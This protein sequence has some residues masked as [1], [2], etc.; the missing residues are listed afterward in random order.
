[1]AAGTGLTQDASGL[2]LTAIT[3]GNATVGAVRYNSTTSTAGQFYGGTT[4]PSG[5]TRLNYAGDFYATRFFGDGSQLTNLPAASIPTNSN[6]QINSLGVGT[7]ASGT[8]GQI[9]A[10]NQITSFFS[11]ERL[12][13]NIRPIENALG[14]LKEIKGVTYNLNN[15]AEQYGY[16]D[17]KE[18]VG[19]IAQDVEKVLPQIVLPAPFDIVVEDGIEVSKSGFDYKTVQYEKLVPLLIQAIKE[20]QVMIEELQKKIG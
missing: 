4:A 10:T 14:K 12:K 2:S 3:A 19:V 11:D 1:V 15:V 17:N 6:L 13:E 7:T 16:G 9:R 18:H 8:A 20:Q 5:N